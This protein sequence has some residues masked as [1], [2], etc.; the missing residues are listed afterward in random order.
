M[1]AMTALLMCL[2][3]CAVLTAPG[4]RTAWPHLDRHQAGMVNPAAA[5]LRAPVGARRRRLPAGVA[6]RRRTRAGVLAD[7]VE[8]LAAPLRSGASIAAAAD[9]VAQAA[10][11]GSVERRLLE[12]LAL[13]CREGREGWLVWSR[14]ADESGSVEAAFVARA[15]RLSEQTGAPLADA[16]ACAAGV[17]R[18]RQRAAERLAVASAGPRASMAVLGLLPL[19]GPAVGFAFGFSPA[20]LY[21]RTPLATAALGVGLLFGALGLLWSRSLLRRALRTEPGPP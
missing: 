10:P 9:A 11:A 14:F 13:V 8:L 4:R 6:V 12:E 1:T 15:W 17:L 19:A 16:L 5:R 3:I 7:V 20:D 2:T 18:E 21:L